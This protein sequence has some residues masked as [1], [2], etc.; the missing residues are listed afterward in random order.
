M[1]FGF[2]R[3]TGNE[4]ER[5]WNND[6]RPSCETT[7]ARFK[8]HKQIRDGNVPVLKSVVKVIDDQLYIATYKKGSTELYERQSINSPS[9]TSREEGEILISDSELRP[10]RK[11]RRRKRKRRRTNSEN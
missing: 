2:F 5:I 6:E 3:R 10:Q 11:K 1:V 8:I 9:A 7:R 4:T